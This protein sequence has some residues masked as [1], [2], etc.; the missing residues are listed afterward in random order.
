[1]VAA[2]SYKLQLFDTGLCESSYNSAMRDTSVL[3]GSINMYKVVK[4]INEKSSDGERVFNLL[5]VA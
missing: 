5:R 2:V 4:N 1:M 3:S